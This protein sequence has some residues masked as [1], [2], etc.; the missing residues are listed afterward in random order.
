MLIEIPSL[1]GR[2]WLRLCQ[3]GQAEVNKHP[4]TATA[5][6]EQISRNTCWNYFCLRWWESQKYLVLTHSH[7][8]S[9]RIVEHVNLKIF[10][11]TLR[12]WVG[13]ENV[14]SWC[15]SPCLCRLN[16]FM[17]CCFVDFDQLSP[18]PIMNVPWVL[19]S[20][21]SL[22]VIPSWLNVLAS[23]RSPSIHNCGVLG[24]Y[25]ACKGY[26]ED[27]RRLRTWHEPRYQ[28]CA[29]GILSSDHSQPF[30]L[31]G[32][33]NLQ[34]LVWSVGSILNNSHT[35][36]KHPFWSNGKDPFI[37]WCACL[38]EWL[39]HWGEWIALMPGSKYQ[40]VQAIANNQLLRV[41][42]PIKTVHAGLQLSNSLMKP[43]GWSNTTQLPSITP[44]WSYDQVMM[45]R[46]SQSETS[47]DTGSL[48]RLPMLPVVIWQ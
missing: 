5:N 12:L 16:F 40:N 35:P 44:L 1:E 23:W 37:P 36:G 6:L 2:Y 18:L 9:V 46:F 15:Q 19:G 32:C 17:F 42:K 48:R 24:L 33:S 27:P 34:Y 21:G 31:C 28:R 13:G 22:M 29:I 11:Q 30:S 7:I 38:L 8:A 41:F 25:R 10:R 45:G 14:N 43:V 20:P 4:A 3:P 26:Q 47:T 39:W